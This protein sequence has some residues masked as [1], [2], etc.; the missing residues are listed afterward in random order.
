[1][2]NIIGDFI[3]DVQNRIGVD[4]SQ[5]SPDIGKLISEVQKLEQ[6]RMLDIYSTLVMQGFPISAAELSIALHKKDS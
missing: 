2:K 1:M 4:I 6:E 5:C 3:S